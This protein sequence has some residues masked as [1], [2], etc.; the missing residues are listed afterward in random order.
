MR[1][2]LLIFTVITLLALP[3]V[4]GAEQPVIRPLDGSTWDAVQ[5][6]ELLEK[7]GV[8]KDAIVAQEP[9]QPRSLPRLACPCMALAAQ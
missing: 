1:R 2:Y 3:A 9:A 7:K 8:T 4:V 5:M 6:R